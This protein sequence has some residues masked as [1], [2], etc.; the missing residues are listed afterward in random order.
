MIYLDV[1][2]GISEKALLCALTKLSKREKEIVNTI[3]KISPKIN[4]KFIEDGRKIEVKG[5]QYFSFYEAQESIKKIPLST[6][7]KNLSLR[8]LKLLGK[9][10]EYPSDAIVAIVGFVKALEFLEFPKISC[11]V[12][13]VGKNISEFSLKILKRSG[14]PF[15]YSSGGEKVSEVG[16][17]MLAALRPACRSKPINKQDVG[18][19][20][21]S[22][23]SFLEAILYAEDSIVEI[24][25]FLDDFNPEF[26]PYAT[27]Q[28][29][30][31]G[32]LNVSV[33]SSLGK[34]GRPGLEMKIVCRKERFDSVT[35]ALFKSTS[36]NGFRFFTRP[37]VLLPTRVEKFR[38]RINSRFFDVRIKTS[39]HKG[40]IVQQK[41]ELEDL[42]A[43]AKATKKSIPEVDR[44]IK[45]QL[46]TAFSTLYFKYQ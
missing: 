23:S 17:A 28:I 30:K 25:T 41:I 7:A 8:I 4:V 40:K 14:L 44:M 22:S 36:T 43:V 2:N 46:R 34:K 11:S 6:K 20:R 35:E 33:I 32:A 18:I 12:I 39:F 29:M 9:K 13:S 21:L 3:K 37:I 38:V 27:E 10:I 1:S 45:K 42:K 19:G 5:K 16:L 26:V 24:E 15:R 31:A